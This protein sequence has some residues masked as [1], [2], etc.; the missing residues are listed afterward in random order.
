VRTTITRVAVCAGIALALALYAHLFWSQPRVK[1]SDFTQLV[2]GARALAAGES[3]YAVVGPGRA[4]AWDFPL[5]YPLPAVLVAIPVAPLPVPVADATVVAIGAFALAW[6]LT[7]TTIWNPQLLVFASTPM[8]TSGQ[9][10]QWS[11]LLTA[12]ALTPALAWVFACKPTIGAALWLYAPSRRTFLAAAGFTVLTVVAWPWWVA[13]WARG[14]DAASHMRAPVQQWGGP[15][16]LLALLRWR[17]REARMLA[18]LSCVPQ[19]PALYEAVPL[20]L[21]VTS[22]PEGVMLVALTLLAGMA[23]AVLAEGA[24]Y[25]G[26]MRING[27]VMVALV[28][29]PC[30]AMVLKRPNDRSADLPVSASNQQRAAALDDSKPPR[31]HRSGGGSIHNPH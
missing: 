17:R 18:A 22:V 14:L 8:L 10:V 26:W 6:A 3:P 11:P 5:L 4:F 25:M 15:L 9:T 21:I 13:D 31:T 28:Y 12:A 7:R 16:L 24:D 27:Q 23:T 19:T 20:F 29:L 2:R 1:P 30:L